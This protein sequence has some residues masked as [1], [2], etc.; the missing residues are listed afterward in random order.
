MYSRKYIALD[1]HKATCQ[2]SV[3]NDSGR[4]IARST[5]ETNRRAIINFLESQPGE[6]RVTF[7]EGTHANWLYDIIQPRVHQVIVCDPRKSKQHGNKSDRID[8][9][10]LSELLRNGSLSPVYHGEKSTRTIQELGR[11]YER[12][13]EDTVRIKNRVKAIYRG[14]GIECEGG[15]V[16]N[17][18][19][20]TEWLKKLNQPGARRRTERLL[21]ELEAIEP[22]QEEAEQELITEGRNHPG[23]KI[24][25]TIPGIGPL[26]AAML[27]AI[28]MTPFRFRTKRQFWTYAGLGLVT[29]SSADHSLINGQVRRSGKAPLVLGLNFGCNHTLKGIFKSAAVTAATRGVFRPYYEQRIQQGVPANLAM[30]TVARKI[31]SVTLVLWKKGEQYDPEKQALEHNESTE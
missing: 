6:L 20:R 11:S 15:E 8:A 2:A 24:L 18:E 27:V 4:L 7:E 25:R 17:R 26:R 10:R 16:F 29:R 9:D 28:V 12:L 21:R 1:V 3:R 14:R 13:T 23:T 31:A 22:L 30:L 19:L 5:F